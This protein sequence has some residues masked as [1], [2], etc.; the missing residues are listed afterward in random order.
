MLQLAARRA[1]G[2]PQQVRLRQG[3]RVPLDGEEL[4]AWEAQKHASLLQPLDADPEQ[5]PEDVSTAP[6][7]SRCASLCGARAQ[8]WG[9]AGLASASLLILRLP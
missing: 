4:Q 7:Q 9:M 5:L 1:H 6:L 8:R 2:P 3:R